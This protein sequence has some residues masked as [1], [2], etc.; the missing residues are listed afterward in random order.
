MHDVRLEQELSRGA[1][2]VLY[3]A[4]RGD[5]PCVA[6][7]VRASDVTTRWFRREAAALAR[8]RDPRV[9]RVLDVG[10]LDG[11]PCLVTELV[12][13][14]RLADRLVSRGP[15]A[16]DELLRLAASLADVLAVVH[17]RG[18]VH[19]ELT[20]ESV[21]LTP[22]CGVRLTD[23]GLV[24]LRDPTLG[25][26]L[27]YAAPEQ[28]RTPHLVD[29]RADLYA[30]GR[31][32][33]ECLGGRPTG[34][35]AEIIA[36]LTRDDRRARYAD[37]HALLADLDRVARGQPPLG[38][39]G[40]A[41]AREADPGP[42]V[43]RDAELAL[44]RESWARARAG[45]GGAVLFEG[46]AGSGKTRFL[47]A[48]A[49][50]VGAPI[51]L[52][53]EGRG[54][55]PMA[56]LRDLFDG[57]LRGD[58]AVAEVRSATLRRAV[59]PH[60]APLVASISAAIAG[61]LRVA[62]AAGERDH[63][64][65]VEAS[66]AALLAI[67]R[68][69]GG[70]VL[71]IDDLQ[72][73]DPVSRDVLARAALGARTAPLLVVAAARS[74]SRLLASVG[75]FVATLG[76]SLA[77]RCLP[78]LDRAGVEALIGAYLGDPA[79]DA[80]IVDHVAAFS[81]GTPLG[82][83]ENLGALLDAGALTPDWGSWRFEL[84]AAERA[85]LAK[86]VASLLHRRLEE[87]APATRQVLEVAAVLGPRIDAERVAAV[88]GVEPADVSFAVDDGERGGLL[89]RRG[90]ATR[91]VHEV[92]RDS[93]LCALSS[94]ERR[95]LHQRAADALG[96][97]D[98]GDRHGLFL[99]AGHLREG[100]RERDPERV[101]DV[102]AAASRLAAESHDFETA[103]DL[104]SLA[105][106][107]AA[108]A[109]L[110]LDA[111][112]HVTAAEAALRVGDI[113]ASLRS[114]SA[115][116]DRSTGDERAR[117]LGRVAWVHQADGRPD[118]AWSALV[119]AFSELAVAPPDDAPR[120][121][122]NVLG[123][124][125]A[126]RFATPPQPS[127][128]P[129]ERA[130]LEILCELH[131][132]AARLSF[133]CGKPARAVAATLASLTSG[134]R[135]GAS[136]VVAKSFA[137]AEVIAVA[138]LGQEVGY[139]EKARAMAE[140]LA[141][142]GTTAAVAQHTM[143]C[144][145]FRGDLDAAI[146]AAERAVGDYGAWLDVGE[147][148][149]CAL[150][151]RLVE[152]VRGRPRLAWTWIE[153]ALLRARRERR[154]TSA[155]GVALAEAARATLVC[156]G[157]DATPEDRALA[158]ADVAWTEDPGA[159]RVMT[160]GSRAMALVEGDGD[161][162]ELERLVREV[163][164]ERPDPRTA[165]LGLAE[166]YVA[167]AH[168]RAHDALAATGV[169]RSARIRALD[170]ALAGLKK[171]SKIEIFRA[172]ATLIE[173]YRALVVGDLATAR[174]RFRD[175][176]DAGLFERAPWLRAGAA[177]GRALLLRRSGARAA[178]DEEAELAVR[179]SLEHG[180][181]ARAR[182]YAEGLGVTVPALG[183][184]ARAQERVPAAA[185]PRP[186][187]LR[188]LVTL[189]RAAGSDTDATRH[190][191]SV[192]DEVMAA[193]GADRG[194]LLFGSRDR[195]TPL[196]VARTRAGDDRALASDERDELDRV[197]V[198]APGD[199]EAREPGESTLAAPLGVSGERVGAVSLARAAG[200]PPF[201]SDDREALAHLAD[202]AAVTL[203]LACVLEER[204]RLHEA[205]RH[206]QKMEAVGQL[207]SGIA[208]DFNNMLMAIVGSVDSLAEARPFDEDARA[209]LDVIRQASR[210]AADLTQQLL[211]FSRRQVL[212]LAKVDL[213]DVAVALAPM[214]RTLLGP[215]ID[216][217]IQRDGAA[218]WIE[219]DRSGLDQAL[220]NIVLN[221]RD[222]IAEA[223]VVTIEVGSVA[224][225][226]AGERAAAGPSRH[227]CIRVSDTGKGIAPDIRPRVF[228]PFFSTKP[229]GSGV[230]LGLAS[231]YGFVTQTGGRIELESEPDAGT[232]I[233]LYFP[234]VE[235][236]PE[237]PAGPPS[238]LEP[239]FGAGASILLAED[240]SVVRRSLVRILEREGFR[241]LVG[242]DGHDALDLALRAE[243]IDVVVSD[244]LMPNMNGPELVRRLR[245]AG[246]TA[247]V[248]F[249]SGYTRGE[250]G[251]RGVL[252]DDVDFLQKPCSAAELV[253]A[254][255]R[256]VL[257]AASVRPR[258]PTGSRG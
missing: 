219:T 200:R 143:M 99:L 108:L 183:A 171:I 16:P 109:G 135:L 3:R 126:A 138:V 243:R 179:I 71:L 189:V 234:I 125:L 10:L 77:T 57:Y 88:L 185:R 236:P 11:R 84:E 2:S 141:D 131:Y 194:A 55:L 120:A 30:L 95:Q 114:F 52:R 180:A 85:W 140:A 192:L 34:P 210:R 203:E 36:N 116:L 86:D 155:S 9:P 218:A 91:F 133:E 221:A 58:R 21:A 37:A 199:D 187:P 44:A 134:A 74:D 186:G 40:V 107:A 81:G 65:I 250:L 177:H 214:L 127:P 167:V 247:P 251:A 38:P 172:H 6:K 145:C 53:C 59:P 121:L 255:R 204:D 175:A 79:P 226:D 83:L 228:E 237:E 216:L 178:A 225:G 170:A 45:R 249:I 209:D 66:A 112:H 257:K 101:R 60:A 153:R 223:G 245:E 217:R 163:E 100:E 103:L 206:A 231:V 98:L 43:G 93:V 165:P 256:L 118:A 92:V 68:L 61:A 164:A 246:V 229:V 182:R 161:P 157:P 169:E 33:A 147:V 97:E 115:A 78:A 113:G 220:V 258:A 14:E 211:A 69:E 242:H 158:G 198:A 119:S 106:E 215:R 75:R 224:F 176:D 117:L 73:L 233:S 139:L 149:L 254:V 80:A 252:G 162:D 130:R 154:S 23:F 104:C 41:G 136:P 168:A 63:D 110:E 96:A 238:R 22:S 12:A 207:A 90:D 174:V 196:V 212:K 82:V 128:A 241:V 142:P 232:T 64:A 4:R 195:A 32:M 240:E 239:R 248:L 48:V 173:G 54:P 67:A 230:G 146:E 202:Q 1:F 253:Q 31:V 150:S 42:F 17:A 35:L 166:Y 208:H 188:A 39:D 111:A 160:W 144:A 76:G 201:T 56:A 7:V 122:A 19:R 51:V 29:G 49:A 197:S 213:N 20:P 28:R 244:V 26:A 94:D 5:V 105:A 87:I 190:A 191:R 102:A 132:Q 181:Y 62:P 15:M 47:A 25:A 50:E 123:A 222:A 148:S 205:L 70:A 235:A 18:L 184:S 8:V 137:T 13:G 193:L 129:E 46:P 151:A 24:A 72:W 227:A 89:E 152:S 156:R 159:H 124:S 27:S